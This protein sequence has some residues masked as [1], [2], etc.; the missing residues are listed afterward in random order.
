[1]STVVE[2]DWDLLSFNL[3]PKVSYV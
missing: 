1:M 2:H 3:H